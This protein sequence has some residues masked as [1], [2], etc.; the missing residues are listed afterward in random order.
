[1][2][3]TTTT[4]LSLIKPEPDVSLDWGTKLNTDLDSIDAIFSSSGT[5]VNLNPNQ[6]N[7][8]DNKKAVFGAG[9]DLQIYHN[10]SSSF[11]DEVGVGDLYIRATSKI[12]LKS[13]NGSETYAQFNANGSARLFYDNTEKLAT[14]STGIDV[15]GNATFADNGKAIFGAGSD[16]EIYH[17][18]SNS[19]IK[20]AGTGSLRLRGTDLRLESS[21]LAHNFI[22]CSEG[23][24]VSVFH[25]DLS[26]LSTT[27]TGINVTGTAT[28]DGLD[29]S[30][31][32][33]IRGA[34]AGRINLD[35]SGVADSSQPFKFLSSDG[36]S[37]IFGTANRS[38]T[39]TT[40][41][42]EIARFDS[43]GKLGIGT[44]SPT[45]AL[46]VN[47]GTTDQVALFES[48]D[49]FADRA[50]ASASSVVQIA[51]DNTEV[52]RFASGGD[53]SFY[54]DTGTSQ[55]LFW[56][57]S[58]ETLAIGHTNPSSTYRL[59]VAGGIRST[60][61]AP[62]Y[63]LREDD[64]SNQT[65][66]M[67]SYG[68]TFSVRDTTVSGSAYPFQ[69][70][71]ATPSST[72]YLDSSGKVGIGTTSPAQALHIGGAGKILIE[73]GG[74]LRSKDTSGN[75]KTI[76]F[77]DS[78]N[79]LAYGWSGAGAVKFMGGGSYTE[80]M[81]IHTDGNVGIGTTSPSSAL[82][83]VGDIE[84]SGNASV[85]SISTPTAGTSNFVAGVNAGN[86]IVSGGN[87]NVVVG[88]EAGTAITTGD[89]NTAIGY[90]ALDAVTTAS[91][92]TAVGYNTLTANTTG[93]N[94]TAVGQG[95]LLVNTTG[96][97]HVALGRLAGQNITTGDGNVCLGYNALASSATVDNEF[98]LGSTSITNLRCNDTSISALSDERDKTDIVDSPYG[99][100]FINT[101]RPVQFK[102]E[103]RDGNGKD[104][105]TR[106]GFIAQ[107]LLVA[108]DGNNAVLDLVS[109]EN[110]ERLEASYGN[111][112]PIMVK[113]IQELS[114][115][116]AELTTRITALEG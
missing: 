69:I 68:G 115:Q 13:H 26:K 5:Q 99:L 36:G 14:T 110:P 17:D 81:R 116:N 72:L 60:G 52:A 95:A 7:F 94:N 98:T 82:D 74:E 96:N 65:W 62:N 57:A 45:N 16:L 97:Y 89:Y 40:N 53:I 21:T 42:T 106:V 92:H 109:E 15:T 59:D 39:S 8:G 12:E 63:T 70:E 76:V 64:A 102:W 35:D 18:G 32:A 86:S 114:A 56:D 83:V 78:S 54:D 28:M 85:G 107:E 50:N 67:A 104:G 91:G 103:S 73:R 58:A 41:S 27:S 108:C 3:D 22:I 29:S 112:L 19:Y 43:S 93:V 11:I 37:L 111:L 79:E 80:R 23:G 4:N 75:E 48:T 101:V 24:G 20:D 66:L 100:D 33:Y 1:M 87:Y 9:S 77:V 10:G 47:S 38:G 55:A 2:A 61:I 6:I 34:S 88:D 49:Q 90:A 113:A 44:T 25:N 84:V 105:W 71:A 46:T 51:V 31:T 30:G